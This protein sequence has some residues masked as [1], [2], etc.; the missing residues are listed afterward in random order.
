[1][2]H[3]IILYTDGGCRPNPG[4]GGWGMHGYMYLLEEPKKSSGNSDYVLTGKGY[5]SKS[6][7]SMKMGAAG[8]KERRAYDRS[9]EVTPLHYIDGWGSFPHDV[10]NNVAEM[11]ATIQG[12]QHA[13]DYDITDLQVYTDSEYVRNGVEKWMDNWM[14]NGWVRHDGTEPK[15]IDYWKQL[16]EA[17]DRLLARGVNVRINWVR[18]HTDKNKDHADILGN[19]KADRLAT[20]GVMASKAGVNKIS[21]EV[22]PAEGYWKYST[23]RHPFLNNRRMYFNTL[24]EYLRP[25]EYYMGEHGKDDDMLGKRISDGA[26]SVVMLDEPDPVLETLRKHQSLL[27]SNTDTIMVARLDHLYRPETHS[28]LAKYGNFAVEQTN[29]WRM[30]LRC[31]DQEP[32]TRE[33]KPAGLAMRAVEAVSEL[34]EKLHEYLAKDPK[35][36]V[37]DLTPLLYETTVKVDKKGESTTLTKLKPEFNVGFAALPVVANYPSD[38]GVK[39]VPVTLTL[40]IDLLDRNALKRLEEMHPTISLISW[41][42]APQA[43]RYATVVEAGKDKG[44]WAGVYSNLR[45]VTV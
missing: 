12:L 3:G 4:F 11:A 15:N 36:V 6:E 28:E 30:D 43:F 20:V 10:S 33:M 24:E 35:I 45:I 21:I 1:M 9:I 7:A 27:A 26:Y 23:E 25:G 41:L 44:I 40:G 37:T 18:S 29:P 5:I 13:A 2:T 38:S 16:V 42:E 22:T 32:L 39:S 34:A 17:R 14:K 8:A 31:L 19:I